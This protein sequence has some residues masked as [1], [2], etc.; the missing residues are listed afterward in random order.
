M[1][2][3]RLVHCC[4]AFCLLGVFSG[5][6]S[7]QTQGLARSPLAPLQDRS[8]QI[9]LEVLLVRLPEHDLLLGE[10][11]WRNVDEQILPTELRGQLAREGFRLGLLGGAM[12][13]EL[14]KVLKLGESANKLQQDLSAAQLVEE[15]AVTLRVL[16]R[17]SGDPAE[18]VTV[19]SIAELPI[20][21]GGDGQ[22]SGQVLRQAE[23]RLLIRPI[24]G[25]GDDVK[26][27]ITPK[28][29][30]GQA[31][32]R[33]VGDEGILRL[34]SGRPVYPLP[35]LKCNLALAPGQMILCTCTED[36][37]GSLGHQFFTQKQSDRWCRKLVIIRLARSGAK[38]FFTESQTAASD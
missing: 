17:Q 2:M 7:W 19:G 24:N 20:L 21:V 15:P 1:R 16:N 28:I 32:S 11:L 27:E 36:N 18:I 14:G 22:V 5:C 25:T 9:E 26:L 30:Y 12:P 37:P 6:G 38:A 3:I 8:D 10:T 29:E 23:P 4:L 33:F 34:D 13:P 35:Q 31:H